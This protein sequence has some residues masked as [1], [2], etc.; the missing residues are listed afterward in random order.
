ME[1][2]KI[3][4]GVLGLAV[5]ATCGGCASSTDLVHVTRTPVKHSLVAGAES[6]RGE[7]F[8]ARADA[9]LGAVSNAERRIPE[10]ALITVYDRQH[11]INGQ[12]YNH[13]RSVTRT[14]ERLAR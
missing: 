8:F 14:T 7:T 3:A 13:Y 12:F 9:R 1:K 5:I 11:T 2:L 10:D 6:A 4:L